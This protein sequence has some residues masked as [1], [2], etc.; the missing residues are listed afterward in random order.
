M[1][2]ITRE[3]EDL[4][5]QIDA[6]TTT[7]PVSVDDASPTRPGRLRGLTGRAGVGRCTGPGPVTPPP[8]HARAVERIG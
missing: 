5:R 7:A 8:G 2:R 4:Q 6:H 3:I 1:I